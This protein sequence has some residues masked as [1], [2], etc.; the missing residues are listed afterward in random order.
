[1]S[2]QATTS[3]TVGPFFTIGMTRLE[4]TD[5]A[6]EG[7]PG[8]RVSIAGRILD[9]NGDPV[10]DALVEIWQADSKGHYAHPEDARSKDSDGKFRGFGRA[11][12]DDEGK[13]RFKTIKPGQ[14]PG[15]EG[16]PQA[17]HIAVSVFARG[18][19]RRLMTRI[20]FPGD[21]ANGED[22]ALGQVPAARRATL[23][24]KQTGK[25]AGELTW[26]IVL[27]GKNETVFFDF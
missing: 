14:V 1:M 13:F 24:A 3:H 21:P 5:L 9:G 4:R 18:L 26:D 27:Q 8:E 7:V 23:I 6:P 10:P 19:Q 16:K 15:P 20:Y 22:Y 2:L 12:T 25:A 17:P 11:H